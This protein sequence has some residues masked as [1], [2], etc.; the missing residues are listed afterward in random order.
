MKAT[1][2]TQ[3]VVP[4][5]ITYAQNFED[6][7]LSRAFGG[8]MDGFYV[9]V[10]AGDPTHVSVTKWFYDL[11]WSGINIEPHPELFERLTAERRRD[12]NLNCGAGA[13]TGE[14]PFFE[15]AI[16]ELSSFDPVVAKRAGSLKITGKSRSIPVF[17]L[18]DILDRHAGKRDINFL[19]I[20]VEG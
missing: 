18:T 3:E 6:V 2:Q 12:I 16:S 15:A 8:Q 11:G 13:T 14:F 4:S 17:T 1:S 5:M 7:L 9:D 10:G 20:D 19:K